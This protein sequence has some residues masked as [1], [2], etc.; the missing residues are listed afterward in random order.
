M[1]CPVCDAA[2][3]DTPRPGVYACCNCRYEWVPVT[4]DMKELA[5]FR[6]LAYTVE[7][8]G[9]EGIDPSAFECAD[10]LRLVNKL[11]QPA[12]IDVSNVDEGHVVLPSPC[13]IRT[14]QRCSRCLPWRALDG[15][16]YATTVVA[17]K[18]GQ[19]VVEWDSPDRIPYGYAQTMILR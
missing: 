16:R 5:E 11:V 6:K 15:Q 9:V 17:A 2:K 14:C 18:D 1:K 7:L 4:S 12:G 19:L 13:E 8:V 3:I 10:V